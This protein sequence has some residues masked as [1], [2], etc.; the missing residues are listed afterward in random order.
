MAYKN[1]EDQKAFQHRYYL[2][3]KEKVLNKNR[4][5]KK[6]IAGFI[7]DYKRKRGCTLCPEN[8][9]VALD[10]HHI[11]GEKEIAIAH[12]RNRMWSDEKILRELE[13]C[14]VV[15]SNCHRKITAG[16]LKI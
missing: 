16:I 11:K 8:E 1:T 13:K 12:I 14:V 7:T 15:C 10:F 2:K 9:P 4:K 6:E 5:R 3:Y